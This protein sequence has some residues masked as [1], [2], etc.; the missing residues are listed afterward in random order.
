MADAIQEREREDSDR[1][2]HQSLRD[3]DGAL[4]SGFIDRVSEAVLLSDQNALRGMVEDLHEADMGDLI[5]ALD[6]DEDRKSVV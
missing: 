4:V 2:E 1:T 3:E 5:E 6:A